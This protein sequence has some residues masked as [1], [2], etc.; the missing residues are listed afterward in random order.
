MEMLEGVD[1]SVE[2]VLETIEARQPSSSR[3]TAA[4]VGRLGTRSRQPDGRV[5]LG[6]RSQ[7]WCGMGRVT[8]MVGGERTFAALRMNDCNG[9]PTDTLPT[10]TPPK[11]QDMHHR[12]S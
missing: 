7:A 11:D 2:E 3:D 8:D 1:P 4:G 9:E 6:K 10:L 12:A 5:Q